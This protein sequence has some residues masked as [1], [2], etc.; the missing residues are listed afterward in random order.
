MTLKNL[1]LRG[2]FISSETHAIAML[3]GTPKVLS[4]HP[5]LSEEE[6]QQIRDFLK[7]QNVSYEEKA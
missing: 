2:M 5:L 6:K 7:D 3:E 1:Q 4:F